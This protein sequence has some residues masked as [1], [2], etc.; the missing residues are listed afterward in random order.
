MLQRLVV[1]FTCIN[2]KMIAS[3]QLW[4]L[5]S[6]QNWAGYQVLHI[7]MLAGGSDGDDGAAAEDGDTAWLWTWQQC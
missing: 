6:Y 3:S 1:I 2:S 5:K 7:G 4:L